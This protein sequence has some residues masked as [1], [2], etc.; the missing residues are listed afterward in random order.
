[1]TPPDTVPHPP[2]TQP[3]ADAFRATINDDAAYRSAATGWQWPLALVLDGAQAFGY[4]ATVAVRLDLDDGECREARVIEGA[5][6]EAPF[7]LRGPYAVWKRIVTGELDPL[8]AV[9]KQELAL[10]GRLHTLIM[11]TRFAKALVAC[12]QAVPTAYPDE[13]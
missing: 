12:A 1:M 8:A 3:W 6:P 11:H 7:I 13:E 4:P 10:E 9:V 5:D 2:F